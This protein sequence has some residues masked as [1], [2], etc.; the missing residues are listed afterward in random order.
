M[1]WPDPIMVK[2][3]QLCV[4]ILVLAYFFTIAAVLYFSWLTTFACFGC[5]IV[6]CDMSSPFIPVLLKCSCWLCLAKW[7]ISS[8]SLLSVEFGHLLPH[9]VFS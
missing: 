1:I 2:V 9:V 4:C 6:F 3:S 7:P 8:L 5:C